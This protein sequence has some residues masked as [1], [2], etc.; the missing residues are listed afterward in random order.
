MARPLVGK[1]V[2]GNVRKLLLDLLAHVI[3]EIKNQRRIRALF[4]DQG[5]A[6]RALAWVE[7]IILGNGDNRGLGIGSEL[8]LDLGDD[9]IAKLR[10]GCAK[11]GVLSRPL[12]VDQ[13]IPLRMRCE[14]LFGG[15][16]RVIGVDEALIKS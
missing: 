12:T 3:G 1:S 7:A 4:C 8:R 16:E 11:L 10:I 2:D 9:V 5:S 15:N 14:E 6:G 13:A